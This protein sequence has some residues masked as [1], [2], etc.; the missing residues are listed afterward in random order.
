MYCQGIVTVYQIWQ[1]VFFIR[2]TNFSF[3][4]QGKRGTVSP[5]KYHTFTECK[6]SVLPKLITGLV[7]Q[8]LGGLTFCWPFF[9]CKGTTTKSKKNLQIFTQ[10]STSTVVIGCHSAPVDGVKIWR[11]CF[12][13]DLIEICLQCFWRFSWLEM[14]SCTELHVDT[15]TLYG[16]VAKLLFLLKFWV[17]RLG[18]KQEVSVCVCT[19]ERP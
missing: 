13:S 3:N 18:L 11:C 4:L 2:V 9:A 19:F 6:C 10:N 8:N 16:S 17:T 15:E 5:S 1:K 7:C 14:N 12:G